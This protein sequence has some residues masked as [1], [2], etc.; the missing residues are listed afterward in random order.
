MNIHP[1]QV[2]IIHIMINASGMWNSFKICTGTIGN[3]LDKT[4]MDNV[5]K[6]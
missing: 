2:M 4:D 1:I 5:N 3:M 6:I